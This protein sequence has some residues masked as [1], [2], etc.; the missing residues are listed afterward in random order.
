M[1]NDFDLLIS[2][3]RGNESEAN[4]EARY[5]IGELGDSKAITDLTI[6]SG[7]TVAKTVL[8]PTSIIPNLRNLLLKNP[9]Q[10]RYVL[11]IKPIEEVVE[12]SIQ[13][14]QSAVARKIHKINLN[15]TFR[16]ALEKRRSDLA[17][18]EI[19][20]TVASGIKRKVELK[21]PDKIILIEVIGSLTGVSIIDPDGV[22]S[23][24]KEKRNQPSSVRRADRSITRRLS[25]SSS[26]SP[27]TRAAS[28]SIDVI[29]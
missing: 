16:I 10:F 13:K 2:S 6:V 17:S 1:L 14:I 18:K 5:I 28:I 21:N 4:F 27:G 19:I 3:A 25:T 24:E 26:T 23:V 29:P 9:W 7:L 20:D 12:S 22:F 8:E 11:K 15:E